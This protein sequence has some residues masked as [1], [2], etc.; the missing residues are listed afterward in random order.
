[1]EFAALKPRTEH[2]IVS[3]GDVKSVGERMAP[4]IGFIS[5]SMNNQ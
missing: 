3:L 1:M 4:I 2:T 5:Y